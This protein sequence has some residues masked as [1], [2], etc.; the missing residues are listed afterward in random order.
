M[1]NI[2]EFEKEAR[3]V[4]EEAI[5]LLVSKRKD[6]GENALRGHEIGIAIRLSDKQARLENLLGISDGTFK[7]K[8]A[9]VGNEQI[10]D[11]IRDIINY[12]IL[13]LLEGRK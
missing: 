10:S 8:E 9:I 5:T 1:S 3:K 7:T 12:G 4:M 2:E 13:F 6:Y 11:T